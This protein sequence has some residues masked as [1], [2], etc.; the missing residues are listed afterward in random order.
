MVRNVLARKVNSQITITAIFGGMHLPKG[1]NFLGRTL[2]FTDVHSYPKR[3]LVSNHMWAQTTNHLQ[4]ES[5]TKG[6]LVKVIGTVIKYYKYSG[7]KPKRDF[8]ID[9]I[10]CACSV[11]CLY[12]LLVGAARVELAT[13]TL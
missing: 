5:L 2:L 3:E 4:Y 8:S 12:L 1:G 10:S 9:I 6:D 13:V 11:K 7:E